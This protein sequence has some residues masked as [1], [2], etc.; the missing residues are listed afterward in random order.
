VSNIDPTPMYPF[1]H[2]L[3]YTRF[4][5]SGFELSADEV[6]TDGELE[7]SCVVHNEATAPGPRSSSSISRTRWRTSPGR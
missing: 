2:G 4:G 1:G 7:V 5:Y 6:P 3:S